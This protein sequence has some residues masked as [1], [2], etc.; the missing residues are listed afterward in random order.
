MVYSM[1]ERCVQM[2]EI[3]E[4]LRHF[5]N[6]EDGVKIA[7][8]LKTVGCTAV[9]V[10]EPGWIWCTNTVQIEDETTQLRPIPETKGS[11]LPEADEAYTVEDRQEDCTRRFLDL[12]PS[13]TESVPTPAIVGSYNY[14][15]MLA[16]TAFDSCDVPWGFGGSA[17]VGQSWY[18]HES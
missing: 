9:V 7:N 15:T 10:A 14:D 1:T 16:N 4:R 2:A 11:D 13:G 17:C 12:I 8:V 3:L 5:A 18:G 6:V